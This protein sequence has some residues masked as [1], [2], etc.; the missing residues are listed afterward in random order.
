M[1]TEMKSAILGVAVLSVCFLTVLA[2]PI[3][4]AQA[5]CAEGEPS[6]GKFIR[7]M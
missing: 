5:D 4:P 7:R 6:I 1:F 2:A 3:V